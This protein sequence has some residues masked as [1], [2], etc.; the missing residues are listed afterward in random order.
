MSVSLL[1]PEAL[2]RTLGNFRHKDKAK[3][4]M[5]HLGECEGQ[6]SQ[7]TKLTLKEAGLKRTLEH[8]KL[9]SQT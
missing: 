6:Y 4:R 9:K 2:E 5:P 8:I 3:L 7:Q 1:R